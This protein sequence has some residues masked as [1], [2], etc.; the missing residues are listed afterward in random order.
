M[1]VPKKA[2]EAADEVLADCYGQANAAAAARL[3][4]AVA[5]HL[6]V[7]TRAE[8]RLCREVAAGARPLWSTLDAVRRERAKARP[9]R[10]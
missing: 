7:R 4:E 9:R 10:G 5:P 3:V 6:G 8:E 2:I 1:K